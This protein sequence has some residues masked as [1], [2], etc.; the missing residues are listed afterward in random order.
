MEP[1]PKDTTQVDSFIEA[2]KWVVSNLST[3]SWDSDKLWELRTALQEGLATVSLIH[4]AVV[5]IENNKSRKGKPPPVIPNPNYVAPA[6]PPVEPPAPAV[7]P[8]GV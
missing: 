5:E 7:P 3:E 4:E 8:A 6:P 2:V 1:I